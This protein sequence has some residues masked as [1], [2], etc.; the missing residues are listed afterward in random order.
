M[1]LA[2]RC[3]VLVVYRTPTSTLRELLL[4]INRSNSLKEALEGFFASEVL[5][6]SS[7]CG[8]LVSASKQFSLEH[9][10]IALC[11]Q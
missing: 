7:F 6:K 11:F 4:E 1:L 5:E 10:P 3:A 2:I 9:A 8:G